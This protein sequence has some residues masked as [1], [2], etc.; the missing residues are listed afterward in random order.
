MA[1]RTEV[2]RFLISSAIIADCHLMMRVEQICSIA[3]VERT[4]NTIAVLAYSIAF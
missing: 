2:P 1:G 4:R 3:N